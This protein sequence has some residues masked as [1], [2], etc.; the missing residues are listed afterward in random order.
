MGG[1]MGERVGEWSGECGGM[2]TGK[3]VNG[4]GMMRE[5]GEWWEM[6]GEGGGMVGGIR[7]NGRG[8]S[9]EW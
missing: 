7:G 5:G 4:G 9:G 2:V 6:M 8:N 3:G 1:I